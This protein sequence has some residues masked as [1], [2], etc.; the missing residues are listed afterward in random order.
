M[1]VFS[2]F[3]TLVGSVLTG[4]L[5]LLSVDDAAARRPAAIAPCC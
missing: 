4:T 5:L 2:D 3:G 1:C